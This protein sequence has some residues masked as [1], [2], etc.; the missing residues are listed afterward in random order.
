MSDRRQ[1]IH[2]FLSHQNIQVTPT[3]VATYMQVAHGFS[4][5]QVAD[6]INRI[7]FRSD[8]NYRLTPQK[9]RRF[10][11]GFSV[12]SLACSQW[13]EVME[14]LQ[15]FGPWHTVCFSHPVTNKLV[16]ELGWISLGEMDFHK[17]SFVEKQF[18][19]DFEEQ[20]AFFSDKTKYPA[21]VVGLH[22]R[23]CLKLEEVKSVCTDKS[24]IARVVQSG[25]P[26]QAVQVNNQD[27]SALLKRVEPQNALMNAQENS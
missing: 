11:N 18:K 2:D 20:F 22:D 7:V 8:D 15:R 3:L 13:N 6:A 19:E 10:L 27:F 1:I 14:S 17:L 5:S 23:K 4:D 26:P 24:L 25:I 21:V 16:A 12:S 9:F